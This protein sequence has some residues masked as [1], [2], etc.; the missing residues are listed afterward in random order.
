V[1]IA[2]FDLRAAEEAAVLFQVADDILVRGFHKDACPGLD[3][4]GELAISVHRLDEGQVIFEA[5]V[6]VVL[7]KSRSG[8]HDA[9]TVLHAHV[10]CQAHKPGGLIGGY[11]GKERLIGTAFKAAAGKLRQNGVVAFQ[12]LQTGFRQYQVL[13]LVLHFHIAFIGMHRQ[14]DV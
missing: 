4:R 8:V 14:G 1:G 3:L 9:G 13:P 12:N 11:K 7:A 10:V 5:Q 6:I 2:V